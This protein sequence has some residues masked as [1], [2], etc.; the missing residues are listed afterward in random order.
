MKLRF[1]DG[2]E[3]NLLFLNLSIINLYKTNKISLEL[4]DIKS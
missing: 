4:N 3:K 2:D 1:W